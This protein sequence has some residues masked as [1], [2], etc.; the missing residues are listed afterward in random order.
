MGGNGSVAHVRRAP[1]AAHRCPTVGRDSQPAFGGKPG[2]EDLKR[3][4]SPIERGTP[5]GFCCCDSS[6]FLSLL[7]AFSLSSFGSKKKAMPRDFCDYCDVYLTHDSAPGRKQHIRGWKH[8]ENVKQYYE[9]YMK[10]YYDQNT[11]INPGILPR[12]PGMLSSMPRPGLVNPALMPP[13]PRFNFMPPPP[14]SV[15]PPP[16]GSVPPPPGSVPKPPAR[17][18]LPPR[19]FPMPPQFAFPPPPL[20]PGVVPPPPAVAPGVPGLL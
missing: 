19:G 12:A 17:G 20:P 14:G 4:D 5:T 8:R 10:A 11:V 6:G 15:P 2:Q 16:P 18:F 7:L 3:S 1:Q 13:P 9:V